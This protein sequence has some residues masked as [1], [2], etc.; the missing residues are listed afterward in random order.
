LICFLPGSG[1][2]L[3]SSDRQKIRETAQLAVCLHFLLT[4]ASAAFVPISTMP[5]WLPE[6]CV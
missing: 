1:F 2:A 3:V 4:F 6:V 5:H